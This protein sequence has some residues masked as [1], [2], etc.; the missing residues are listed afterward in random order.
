MI[1]LF[2]AAWLSVLL[3]SRLEYTILDKLRDFGKPFNCVLCMG[4]WLGMFASL[5][6]FPIWPAIFAGFATS[7]IAVILEKQTRTLID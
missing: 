2:G 4:F 5:L 3:T 6:I 7:A 1:T